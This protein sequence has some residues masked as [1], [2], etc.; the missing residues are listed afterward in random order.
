M[1]SEEQN[2]VC[3]PIRHLYR[4]DTIDV[5]YAARCCLA[6][7]LHPLRHLILLRRK[8]NSRG[9][10]VRY[11]KVKGF[12]EGHPSVNRIEAGEAEPALSGES[13]RPRRKRLKKQIQATQLA[14]RLPA[15]I[16]FPRLQTR[17]A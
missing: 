6:K 12:E 1:F 10:E 16:S 4:I 2:R 14:M 8:Q 7:A 5:R 11:Q 9:F 3:P 17:C 15:G 13:L